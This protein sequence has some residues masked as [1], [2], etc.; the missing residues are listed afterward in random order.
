MATRPLGK[1][2]MIVSS[3]FD[4]FKF[5]WVLDN[6]QMFIYLWFVP[7]CNDSYFIFC[8]QR[9]R[10]ESQASLLSVYLCL[11]A[12]MNRESSLWVGKV[13]QTASSGYHPRHFPL[14]FIDV[15]LGV[16]TTHNF[17]ITF[18][19]VKVFR[20]IV[21]TLNPSNSGSFSKIVSTN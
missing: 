7:T 20:M 18:L 4:V 11:E 3:N 10:G 17:F 2:R 1:L 6:D 16:G 9:E 15:I 13:S 19:K 14:I 5:K 12:V 21:L 8:T